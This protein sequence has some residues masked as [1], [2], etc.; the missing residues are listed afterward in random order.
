MDQSWIG[1]IRDD[2]IDRV[3]RVQMDFGFSF[4]AAPTIDTVLYFRGQTKG[5]RD[6]QS[7][8]EMTQEAQVQVEQ[9]KLIFELQMQDIHEQII[10]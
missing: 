6:G 2:G 10:Y 3:D 9:A 5:D 1:N 4:D 7:Q 8:M